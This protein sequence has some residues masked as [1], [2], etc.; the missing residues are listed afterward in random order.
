MKRI[1]TLLLALTLLAALTVPALADVIWE[2][3]NSFFQT[4]R[5]ECDYVYDHRYEAQAN[6]AVCADPSRQNAVGTVPAGETRFFD[7]L[8]TDAAGALWGY[9]EQDGGWLRLSDFRRL[10]TES[11]FYAEHADAIVDE[12]GALPLSTERAFCSYTFPGSGTTTGARFG[13]PDSAGLDDPT[14]RYQKTYTDEAGRKWGLASFSGRYHIWVCL[15]DPLDDALP[16]TAPKYAGEAAQTPPAP[17]PVEPAEPTTEPTTEPV[18]PAEAEPAEQPVDGPGET[19]E[20]TVLPD[21][22]EP[23]AEPAQAE[24]P[25]VPAV[26]VEEVTPALSVWVLVAMIGALAAVSGILIA[27]LQ[28]KKK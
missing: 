12:E 15:T 13:G 9:S 5:A 25:D 10:Y 11:V 8:W 27:V 18:L 17:A 24:H 2:P 14:F 26:P 19:Q 4:H 3:E 23:P 16:A 20:A 22:P 21:A 7:W 1:R 6:A 28:R